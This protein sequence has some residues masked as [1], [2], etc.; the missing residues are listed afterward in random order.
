MT[1]RHPY[2]FLCLGAVAAVGKED[3]TVIGDQQS[4]GAASKAAE[5][6]NVGEMGHEQRV[7]IYLRARLGDGAGGQRDPWEEC[8]KKQLP[9][10]GCQQASWQFASSATGNWSRQLHSPQKRS[11]R[12]LGRFS[13][14][15]GGFGSF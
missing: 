10:A 12:I 15:A 5:I 6:V 13:E 9:V 14:K 1:M 7:E 11:R 8:S 2:F 3:G 4:R